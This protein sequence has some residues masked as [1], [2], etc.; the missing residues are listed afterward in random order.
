LAAGIEDED[1]WHER[2]QKREGELYR[3]ELEWVGEDPRIELRNQPLTPDEFEAL[4][5]KLTK[6]DERSTK[7]PWTFHILRL[8]KKH[9]GRL[10][11]LLADEMRVEKQ[12]LKP[13]IRKLKTLGLTISL[14]V[15][16]KL[17]RRGASFMEK[18]KGSNG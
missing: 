1:R 17:S 10:A 12:W 2:L 9:P 11:Q 4:Y 15:G 7:G 5:F 6:M 8:I 16:Y 13:N 18:Q 14:E 3:I